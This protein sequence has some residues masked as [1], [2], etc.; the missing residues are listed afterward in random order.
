MPDKRSTASDGSMHRG[1]PLRLP[2]VA[3]S[4]PAKASASKRCSGEA[5][6][7]TP[8]PGA[9]GATPASTVWWLALEQ[10]SN[11]IGAAGSFSASHSSA[12]GCTS[13]A[14]RAGSSTS[15]AKGSANGRA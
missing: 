1:S 15:S 4:G 2:L 7:I 8:S 11:T 3:T 14:R 6:R 9:P 13:S 5:G 10:R 12:L